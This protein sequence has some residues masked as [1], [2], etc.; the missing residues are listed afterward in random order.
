MASLRNKYNRLS[1]CVSLRSSDNISVA[2]I[3]TV[4]FNG[5]ERMEMSVFCSFI[6]L[7]WIIS[8]LGI[9]VPTH[10][11][12]DNGVVSDL[13]RF[14]LFDSPALMSKDMRPISLL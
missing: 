5:L 4:I 6:S 3:A 11:K 2:N 14:A 8:R 9:I 12:R 10:S 7:D 1:C 13:L